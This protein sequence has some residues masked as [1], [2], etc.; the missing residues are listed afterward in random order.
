LEAELQQLVRSEQYEK[1]A[2]VR[3][4]IAKLKSPARKGKTG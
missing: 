2:E 3:D 1:A 4:R